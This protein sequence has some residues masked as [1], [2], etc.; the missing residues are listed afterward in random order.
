ML[1]ATVQQVAFPTEELRYTFFL[2]PWF[3][4]AVVSL[5]IV[6]LGIAHRYRRSDDA[7]QRE[8]TITAVGQF[9]PY[10]VIGLLLT[11][12]LV[13]VVGYSAWVLPGLWMILTGLGIHASRAVLPPTVTIVSMFYLMAGLVT[14]ACGRDVAF[15]PWTMGSVFGFGQLLAAV[16][17][18]QSERPVRDNGEARHAR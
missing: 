7:V 17:L 14:L 8:L 9:A 4:A 1:T 18:W 2:F 16:V 11:V 5:L 6:G 15:L 13:D 12:V 3:A 10:L